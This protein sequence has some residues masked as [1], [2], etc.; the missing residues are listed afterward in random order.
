M[1]CYG[2]MEYVI[3][4]VIG[5]IIAGL[6]MIL[7]SHFDSRIARDSES[8]EEALHYIQEEK[9]TRQRTSGFNRRGVG[10]Y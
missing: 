10:G 3:G 7:N 5:G 4:T 8:S 1:L 9:T 2:I 6:A